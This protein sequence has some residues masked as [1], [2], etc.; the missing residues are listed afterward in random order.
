MPVLIIPVWAWINA[1]VLIAAGAFVWGKLS[2][3]A[4]PK[5]E[6]SHIAAAKSAPPQ[7]VSNT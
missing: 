1:V 3:E 2:G 7:P 4:A 5:R 6:K